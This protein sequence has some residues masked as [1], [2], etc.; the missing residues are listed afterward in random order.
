[1]ESVK[2]EL[3]EHEGAAVAAAVDAGVDEEL[4]V[5]AQSGDPDDVIALDVATDRRRQEIRAAARAVGFDDEAIGRIRREGAPGEPELGWRA[6]V[7]ATTGRRRRKNSVESAARNAGLDVDALYAR[8]RNLGEDGV[9]FLGR[10]PRIGRRRSRRRRGL[11]GS[12]TTGSRAFAPR[13]NRRS[14]ARDW[15]L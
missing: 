13:R 15:E 8:A 2:A 11:S 1:M 12:T 6:V 5:T 4:V 10:K 7:E 9:D 14:P 3:K